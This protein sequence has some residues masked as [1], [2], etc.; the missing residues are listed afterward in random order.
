MSFFN[1]RRLFR[2][3]EDHSG[4]KIFSGYPSESPVRIYDRDYW[5]SDAWDPLSYGKD[6]DFS[7]SFFEQFRELL[8]SVP[9][10]AISAGEHVNSDY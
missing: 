2:K 5:L 8:K 7:K 4:K 1:Q 3:K 6:Y 10:M 9:L